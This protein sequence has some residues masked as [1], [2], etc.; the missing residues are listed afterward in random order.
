MHKIFMATLFHSPGAMKSSIGS[1][2]PG[3]AGK[4]DLRFFPVIY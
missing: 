1:W 4:E 2:S 3:A